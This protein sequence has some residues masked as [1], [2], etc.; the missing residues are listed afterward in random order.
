MALS[1]LVHLFRELLLNQSIL[2]FVLDILFLVFIIHV[3]N[4]VVAVS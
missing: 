1:R 3:M 4:L 2:S